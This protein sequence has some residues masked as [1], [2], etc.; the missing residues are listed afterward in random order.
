MELET[1]GASLRRGPF[2]YSRLK[3]SSAIIP[4]VTGLLHPQSLEVEGMYL[5]SLL[6]QL[7]FLLNSRQSCI[8]DM[9]TAFRHRY[10]GDVV[11]LPPF[12]LKKFPKQLTICLE[13][14]QY[15]YG[16]SG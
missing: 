2:L 11:V 4:P 12:F 8:G 7:A 16:G 5:Y 6:L 1:T 13:T 14:C 9:L 3:N 15:I 10:G